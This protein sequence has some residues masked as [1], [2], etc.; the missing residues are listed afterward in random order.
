MNYFFVDEV[1]F[2]IQHSKYILIFNYSGEFISCKFK[3]Y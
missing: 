2:Y 3:I 1:Y